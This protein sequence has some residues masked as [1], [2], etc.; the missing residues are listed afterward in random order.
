MSVAPNEGQ[1]R[2][3]RKL[4]SR[5]KDADG[6]VQVPSV[7]E[8]TGLERQGTV[9]DF[10]GRKKIGIRK[11]DIKVIHT[12]YEK[13]AQVGELGLVKVTV[14]EEYVKFH[15]GYKALL[16]GRE[17]NFRSIRTTPQYEQLRM[18]TLEKVSNDDVG[19]SERAVP[20]IASYG[21]GFLGHARTVQGA[22]VNLD[23][24]GE[25]QYALET[26]KFWRLGE[27]YEWPHKKKRFKGR[28]RGLK[29]DEIMEVGR[30]VVAEDQRPHNT[31]VILKSLFD[32]IFEHAREKGIKE[33]YITMPTHPPKLY[34]R[35]REIG[36]RP[37]L[38]RGAELR[39]DNPEAQKVMNTYSGY[40]REQNP[41]L[42]HITVPGKA[43]SIV[44]KATDVYVNHWIKLHQRELLRQKKVI[45]KGERKAA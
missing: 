30:V 35:L 22:E 29:E 40:W 16:H 7:S 9:F 5:K 38:V 20:F 6:L 43:G 28:G 4:G 27:G 17:T 18:E 11:K 15:R 21:L 12:D 26:Y 44:R 33:L 24:T 8:D 41:K 23:N 32:Q 2:F 39:E 37:K 45:Q 19:K 1:R 25:E 10:Q 3:F 34:T 42:Y 13:D 36:I 31:G 14:A